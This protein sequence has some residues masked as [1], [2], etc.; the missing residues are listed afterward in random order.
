MSV[1]FGGW[2]HWFHCPLYDFQMRAATRWPSNCASRTPATG[3]ATAAPA[4]S[5]TRSAL[6][7]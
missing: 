7:G 5:S 4:D 2:S 3:I 6:A 1:K